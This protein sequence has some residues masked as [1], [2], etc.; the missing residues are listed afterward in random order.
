MD[1][2]E[3]SKQDIHA[4]DVRK[5]PASSVRLETK[6]IPWKAKRSISMVYGLA[7]VRATEARTALVIAHG[8]GGS[9]RSRFVTFFHVEMARRG[10]VTVKFNFP[11]MERRWKLT[12]TPD[13][14]DELV[15]CYRRVLDEVAAQHGLEKLV[16]GGLSLGAAVASHVVAD[17]P[18]RNDVNGLFYFSYPIHRPREPEELG[19]KHLFRISKPMLFIAGTRDPYAQLDQLKQLVSKLG[20]QSRLQVVEGADHSLKPRHGRVMYFKTLNRVADV[21]EQWVRTTV[22]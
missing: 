21:L 10:L 15:G 6:K 11:Y 17:E 7:P 2:D 20:P 4:E 19:V 5:A 14:K 9:I 18:G 12:R 13:T 16:I 1:K 22:N 8:A 3:E